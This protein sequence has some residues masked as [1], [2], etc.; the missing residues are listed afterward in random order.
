MIKNITKLNELMYS[1]TTCIFISVKFV[2]VGLYWYER[3]R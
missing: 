2:Y 3:E 1:K